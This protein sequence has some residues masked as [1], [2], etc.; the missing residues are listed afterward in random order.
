MGVQARARLAA[1]MAVV[2]TST[3]ARRRSNSMEIY[4]YLESD[5][6]ME[7]ERLRAQ[8][9]VLTTAIEAANLALAWTPIASQLHRDA[10]K[11]LK[12]ATCQP[13]P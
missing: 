6:A 3:W 13:T 2:R 12:E 1:S 7:L 5:E 11:L 10:I 4:T 8:V 9:E